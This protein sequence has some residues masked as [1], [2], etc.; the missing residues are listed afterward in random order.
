MRSLVTSI[1]TITLVGFSLAATINVPADFATI[2]EGINA[3]SN[4]DTVR[5]ATGT[6]YENLDFGAKD[7]ILISA[8]GAD[9]TIIDGSLNGPV[10]LI[11]GGQSS[12]AELNGFTI[13][14]GTGV[15]SVNTPEAFFAGGVCVRYDSNPTLRNLIVQNNKVAGTGSSGGGLGVSSGS[16]PLIEDV[17]VRDNEAYYGGG[18]FVFFSQPTF[19]N[20]TVYDNHAISSAGGVGIQTSEVSFHNSV[21]YGNQAE[22][23]AGAIWAYDKSTVLVNRSTI[24]GNSTTKYTG[25]GI[26]SLAQNKVHVLNSIFWGNVPDQIA[27]Y[28][29]AAYGPG[30]I[31]VAYSDI[32]HGLLQLALAKSDTLLFYT[33]NEDMTPCFTDV[34]SKDFHLLDTSPC[35]DTGIPTFIWKGDT[36]IDLSRDEYLGPNPEMGA[37]ESS[38]TLSLGYELQVPQVVVLQQNFPNPFNPSTQ[39]SWTLPQAGFVRL[40]V[41]TVRG[42]HVRT[43]VNALQGPGFHSAAWDARDKNGLG[44]ESG[45]YIYRLQVDQQQISKRMLLIH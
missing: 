30:S 27:S 33:N 26:F 7:V 39:I 43:L 45:I 36:L 38:L 42:D 22:E 17:I 41:L 20:I 29:S 5:V 11:A 9:S 10:V 13:Q 31:G 28:V 2:Q 3:A 14:H 19:K 32:Q 23:Y 12:S 24:Y 15:P 44:L 4:G 34:G 16:Q 37:F 40:D 1:L 25:G 35:I 18:I 21:F 8:E 6:Y